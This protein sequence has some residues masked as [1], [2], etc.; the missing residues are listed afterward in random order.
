[1]NPENQTNQLAE[2]LD[3]E[4]IGM[5]QWL[6]IALLSICSGFESRPISSLCM[7]VIFSYVLGGSILHRSDLYYVLLL[8]SLSPKKYIY[9]S[10]PRGVHRV[11]WTQ[12]KPYQAQL[13]LF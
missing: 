13:V 12:P 3:L 2:Y 11:G 1:M 8:R 7:L 5:A 4:N 6:G 9:I 10:G